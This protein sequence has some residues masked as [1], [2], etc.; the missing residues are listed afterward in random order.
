MGSL[1]FDFDLGTADS[2]LWSTAQAMGIMNSFIN[3]I[4]DKVRLARERGEGENVRMY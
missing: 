3:D 1:V 4:F 2:I